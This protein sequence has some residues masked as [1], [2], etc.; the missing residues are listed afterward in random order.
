MIENRQSFT[1]AA[2]AAG[3][4]IRKEKQALKAANPN[5][6]EVFVVRD[7]IRYGW[8]IRQFGGVEIEKAV[9]GFDTPKIAR[10]AGV[11][12]LRSLPSRPQ[13]VRSFSEL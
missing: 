7:G 1:A 11:A 9:T 12:A 2:R 5:P 6:L 10:A 13:P 8:E 3:L 4:R